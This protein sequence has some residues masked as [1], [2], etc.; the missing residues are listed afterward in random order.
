MK[1][2]ATK[3]VT[4]LA[5]AYRDY[6][7]ANPDIGMGPSAGYFVDMAAK[8]LDLQKHEYDAVEAEKTLRNTR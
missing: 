3:A 7:R 5:E 6:D 1:Q 8:A 2:F 4:K